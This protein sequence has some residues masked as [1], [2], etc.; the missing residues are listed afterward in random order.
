MPTPTRIDIVF[1]LFDEDKSGSL[2]EEELLNILMANH[3]QSVN[4]V[5]NKAKTILRFTD[6]DNSGTLSRTEFTQVAIKFPN[7]LF[8]KMRE[9]GQLVLAN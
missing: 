7:I 9:Q 6:A 3:M 4:M 1:D 5:R 2:S 8:P